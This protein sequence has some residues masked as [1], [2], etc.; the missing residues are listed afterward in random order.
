MRAAHDR[1]ARRV[2][3]VA[4][5]MAGWLGSAWATRIPTIQAKLGLSEGALALAI[6]GLEAGAIVGLP[7]GAALV[8]RLGSRHTLQVG[9]AAMAPALFAVGLAPSL[10]ALAGALAAMALAN[11]AVDVAMNA[12]GI[13][14]ERRSRRALLSRLHAWHPLG[15]L[16]GGL[17]GTAAAVA[18]VSVVA[19]FAVASVVGLAL[20]VATSARLVAEPDGE[21]ERAFARP[22]RRLLLLG[23][24]AFCAFGL[25]GA[26]YNWSAVDARSEHGA[27]TGLAAGAFAGFALALA[28]GR[29]LGDQLVARLGRVRL[30]QACAAVAAAGGAVVVLATSPVVGL[31]GWA[32]F[33]LGLAAVAPTVLGAAARTGNGPP[34]LAIAS[35]TTIG[36]L[37]SFTTPP[38]IGALAEATSLS[39]A[40]TTLVAVSAILG[41][42][43]KPALRDQ[44]QPPASRPGRRSGHANSRTPLP[45]GSATRESTARSPVS[46][47]T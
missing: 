3:G 10:V 39:A 27:P 16:G 13:E 20:A 44:A 43:A 14:L 46:P 18:H 26:A 25:D 38:V 35:V 6:L 45:A 29:L 33:G 28:L 32:L 9:F 22:S 21:R 42:L 4:F 1:S 11:S 7:A 17:A 34:A 15:L 31:A 24:L 23:L 36:Y 40:L 5:F 47:V 12:Q 41:A 8:A 30:L 37:G 2:A 19:H